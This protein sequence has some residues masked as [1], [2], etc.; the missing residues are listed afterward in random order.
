MCRRPSASFWKCASGRRRARYI[1]VRE[2]REK[3]EDEGIFARN[4]R[5]C[6]N[7]IRFKAVSESLYHRHRRE[8]S[9]SH[10]ADN[11]QPSLLMSQY[12]SFF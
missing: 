6:D 5:R 4:C 9:S 2:E 7:Y 12:P 8:P 10:D 11:Q 3:E 1:F